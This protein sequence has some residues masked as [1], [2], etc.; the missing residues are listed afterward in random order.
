MVRQILLVE[1]NLS[2]RELFVEILRLNKAYELH[3]AENGIQALEMLETFSPDLIL[4]D[5][6][7][8]EMDGLAVTRTIKSTPELA[9]IPIVALSALAMK[10]DIQ[11]ALEAGCVDYITK[12]IRIRDFL[13]K[14]AQYSTAREVQS[15]GYKE[16]T[17]L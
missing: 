1:D 8:P 11:S 16:P 12:P 4:M 6:H 13:E 2:N 3:V 15:P 5:I 9:S 7:M 14:V 10:S 17:G